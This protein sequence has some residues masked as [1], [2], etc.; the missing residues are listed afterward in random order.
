M[1][2]ERLEQTRGHGK[3]MHWG[4]MACCVVMLLPIGAYFIAGSATPGVWANF[5][6]FTPLLL[7]IG[8]HL[9]VHKFMG[10]SCHD[11]ADDMTEQV[12]PIK[13]Q[14]APLR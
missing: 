10:K 7:C 1:H 11:E 13:R 4:M 2:D 5:G 6:A 9:V 8:A 14:V 12:E 3:L